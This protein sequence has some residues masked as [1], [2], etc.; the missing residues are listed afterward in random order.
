MKPCLRWPFFIPFPETDLPGDGA[1]ARG[2]FQIQAGRRLLMAMIGAGLLSLL[3]CAAFYLFE[4]DRL[5]AR[6]SAALAHQIGQIV[7]TTVQSYGEP[8]KNADFYWRAGSKPDALL[9]QTQHIEKHPPLT[10]DDAW[11]VANAHAGMRLFLYWRGEVVASSLGEAGSGEAS[12]IIPEF[13]GRTVRHGRLFVQVPMRWDDTPESPILIAQQPLSLPFSLP[14]I[15]AAGL[16]LW[17]ILA[18]IIWLTVGIWL[19]KALQQV[20]FLA[21]HDPLTGLINRAA[22]RVGLPHMLA[23]SRRN[24]TLLALLYLDL[25]RFKTINDSLG[26]AIGDLVL[27]ECASRLQACVRDT[28]FVARLGGDE[29]VIVIGELRDAT[30]AANIARKII[31]A[32]DLPILVGNTPL[33]TSVSIGIA[34]HPGNTDNPEALIMHADSAMYVAKQSGRNRYHFYDESLGAQ[35][36]QRLTLE[37]EMREALEKGEFRLHYQPIVSTSGQPAISGFEALLRWNRNG[38]S[39]DPAKFI[40]LAE[41]TGLILP[42]GEWALREACRQM[43]GWQLRYPATRLHSISVNVSIRQLQGGDFPERVQAVLDETG[44]P[45]TCLILELTESLYI[46]LKP[47]I[48][49]SLQQLRQIGIRLAMDDF[50]TGYSALAILTRLPLDRLKI[51][52]SFVAHLDH[53]DELAIAGTIIAIGRQLGLEVVA[54][55]VETEIQARLLAERGC[56]LHQGWFYGKAEPSDVAESWLKTSIDNNSHLLGC[57][58]RYN[59]NHS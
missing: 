43:R 44:L 30:D 25:D 11:L 9:R 51:D 38:T 19:S 20:Q 12:A 46:D 56:V 18:S 45:P 34:T 27:K 35:A 59:E 10:L 49:E 37:L 21:Y 15:A 14:E 32:L 1:S 52:R 16:F 13:S 58:Y 26:H 6:Q 24:Q 42:L 5:T 40:P 53:T 39:I 17:A 55:G 23:E 33:Q 54:E 36:S 7:R 29:F 57:I 4:V 31:K 50:G 3:I 28:D 2:L 8:E 22:L 48:P 47:P 41:E